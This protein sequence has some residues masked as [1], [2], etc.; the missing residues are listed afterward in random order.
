VQCTPPAVRLTR[1]KAMGDDAL[2]SPLHTG[3]TR[4]IRKEKKIHEKKP[5]PPPKKVA[6]KKKKKGV[7]EVDDEGFP[8]YD[9]SLFE[10]PPKKVLRKRKNQKKKKKGA[11]EVDDDGFELYDSTL[12]ASS[13]VLPEGLDSEEDWCLGPA[14]E[15]NYGKKV[16]PF[17]DEWQRQLPDPAKSLELR[18]AIFQH[19]DEEEYKTYV[20]VLPF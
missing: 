16:S 4:N 12:F 10:S 20:F 5:S 14:F 11:A 2:R 6:P 8:L 15:I 13:L 1:S 9:E 19:R 18:S 17:R 7:V 3:E